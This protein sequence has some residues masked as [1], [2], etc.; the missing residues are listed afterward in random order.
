MTKLDQIRLYLDQKGAELAIFSD[1][2]TI[3][4]LTGFF[5]DPHERQLFLFV[6]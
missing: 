2:V 6:Y 3:N 5:C 4:Y 1:P